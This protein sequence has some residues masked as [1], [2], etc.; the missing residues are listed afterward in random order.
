MAEEALDQDGT[1]SIWDAA[2]KG[3]L[4]GI[5]FHLAQDSTYSIMPNHRGLTPLHFA[6]KGGHVEA[7]LF[8]LKNGAEIDATDFDGKTP[9][10]WAAYPGHIPA[11]DALLDNGANINH[12]NSIDWT[13]LHWAVQGNHLQLVKRLLERGAEESL[14]HG[15]ILTPLYLAEWRKDSYEMINYLATLQKKRN[16]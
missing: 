9:L 11:V 10:M 2:Y 5:K 7:I 8:L 1:S 15:G 13:T 4:D 14:A 12:R 6:A 16:E 3:S